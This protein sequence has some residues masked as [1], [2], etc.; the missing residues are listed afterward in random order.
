MWSQAPLACYSRTMLPVNMRNRFMA[1]PIVTLIACAAP[2]GTAF[3]KQY[4]LAELIEMA[5]RGNHGIAAGGAAATAMEAQVSEAWRNWLPSGDLLSFVAP[6]PR[7]QCRGN[8]RD[9]WDPSTPKDVREGNC[10]STDANFR[11]NPN[12]ITQIEGAWTRT[13]L[14]VVQPLWDFGK[15]SAGVAAAKAG[16][17]ALREKQAGVASDVEMNVRKAYWGLKLAREL[18]DALDEGTGYIGQA[19]TKLDKQLEEGSGNVTVTDKLRLRTVRAE[20]D[21]RTLETK[22]MAAFALLG[23]KTLLGAEAPADLDVDAE[24]FEPL[25]LEEHPAAYY[26]E[27]ARFNRPEVRALDFAVKAKH[28]LADL[29]RR[30][31]YPDLVLLGTAS[32]AYAPTIDT[33]KN[34]FAQNP[35]NSLGAGVAAALRMPLDLGPKLARANRLRLEAEESDLRRQE[36]LGGIALEVRKAYGELTEARARVEA[37]RKGE[38][39]G[40]AWVTAVAQ[41]FAIG[42]AEARDFSDA[43]MAFFTMRARYLQSVFDLNVAA[44]ALGRAT[45]GAVPEVRAAA[46][47]PSSQN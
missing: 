17:S 33:P 37:V 6:V 15:I 21:A 10:I 7:L 9:P 26:E 14:R 16:V 44:A 42:L 35:F 5:R 30:R 28:A 18:L 19:Q 39:A 38:R 43:L 25:E 46:A 1:I 24:A 23:L 27:Q 40:K 8:S 4:T 47:P 11:D 45:G 20:V 12:I 31:E 34:A 36:A 3:A 2:A 13:E 29:E 41:N 22:R 32:F